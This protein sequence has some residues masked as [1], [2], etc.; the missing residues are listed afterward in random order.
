MAPPLTHANFQSLHHSVEHACGAK[1][2]LQMHVLMLCCG[3]AKKALSD[4]HAGPQL[5]GQQLTRK[6]YDHLVVA[7]G[8]QNWLHSMQCSHFLLHFASTVS[9]GML[10]IQGMTQRKA[11]HLVL[12]WI[13]VCVSQCMPV[14]FTNEQRLTLTGMQSCTDVFHTRVVFGEI[15]MASRPASNRLRIEASKLKRTLH[16]VGCLKPAG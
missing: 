2:G 7:T 3:S 14:L 8:P 4:H 10:H 11:V 12:W 16:N 15:S 6:V 13:V 1:H 5:S 9:W